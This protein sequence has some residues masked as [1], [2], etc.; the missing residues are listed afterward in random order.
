MA[1][2]AMTETG[3]TSKPRLFL[4]ITSPARLAQCTGPVSALSVCHK[5]NVL[6]GAL[7]AGYA[8]MFVAVV[9][10][11]GGDVGAKY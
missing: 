3:P 10:N 8:W 7:R 5:K 11:P 9:I 4:Q 1:G 6:G 2:L